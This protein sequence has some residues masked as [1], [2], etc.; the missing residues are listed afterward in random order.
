MTAINNTLKKADWELDFYSRPIVDSNGKKK[1]EVLIS[2]TENFTQEQPF[3]WE[4]RCPT[5]EVNS[6]WLTEALKEALKKAEQEGWELPSKLRFWRPSM[7]TII[8]KAAESVG[9]DPISS[10]R[11]YSLIQWLEER[12]RNIYPQ[13][14]G[15]IGGPLAPTFSP[16]LNQSIPLPEALRGDAWTFASILF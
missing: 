2:S 16:I 11:T 8:T 10:R 14:E 1:W 15:Y 7:K 13:E 3:R 6:K 4:K 12:N 9:L 5:G